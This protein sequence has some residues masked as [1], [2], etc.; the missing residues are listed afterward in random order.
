[1]V[2]LEN[3]DCCLGL[4]KQ[5]LIRIGL[6]NHSRFRSTDTHIEGVDAARLTEYVSVSV[7]IEAPV[8]FLRSS[9]EP[10]DSFGLGQEHIGVVSGRE[11]CIVV[12]GTLRGRV[13]AEEGLVRD[14][15]K[16][17]KLVVFRLD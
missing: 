8:D 7:L 12:G 16:Q 14:E 10:K 5:A 13:V 11:E 17:V 4:S 1:L 3:H 9:L 2:R 6:Q 15:P